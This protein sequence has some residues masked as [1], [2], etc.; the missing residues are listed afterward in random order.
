MDSPTVVVVGG[1]LAGICAA[2][3][4]LET[5]LGCT[6]IVLEA[7]S[8]LGGRLRSAT[9]NDIQ[10]TQHNVDIGGQF[11]GPLHTQLQELLKR[12]QL[13]LVLTH[14]EGAELVYGLTLG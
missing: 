4:I 3:T 10:G 14:A 5:H 12:F 6:V 13:P 8:I 1:G 7:S 11:V 9:I 2:E